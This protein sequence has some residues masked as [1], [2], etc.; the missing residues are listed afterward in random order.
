MNLIYGI[1][2]V[3][4]VIGGLTMACMFGPGE[5]VFSRSNNKQ[6]IFLFFT[7][8]PLGWVCGTV[9]LIVA[10]TMYLYDKLGE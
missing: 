9:V 10:G 4:G 2:F 3:W 6:I 5:D 1:L 8:G 7:F